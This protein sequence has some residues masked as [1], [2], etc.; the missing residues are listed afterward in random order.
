MPVTRETCHRLS[1]LSLARTCR[2]TAPR[3][4]WPLIKSANHQ[5]WRHAI[6]PVGTIKALQGQLK[7]GLTIDDLQELH[8]AGLA[9]RHVK[10]VATEGAFHTPAVHG[11]Q[12]QKDPH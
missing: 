2:C 8:G 10:Q 5:S 6:A 7:V 1:I 9:L 11:V 12:H 3:K 4:A